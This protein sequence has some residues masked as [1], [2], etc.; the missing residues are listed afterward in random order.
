MSDFNE[1]LGNL[2]LSPIGEAR[3]TPGAIRPPDEEPAPSPVRAAARSALQ[4]FL[5]DRRRVRAVRAG[6][7]VVVI[8][9]TSRPLVGGAACR[10]H[11]G[12]EPHRLV[13]EA[14]IAFDDL[15][16]VVERI[17]DPSEGQVHRAWAV[18]LKNGKGRLVRIWTFGAACNEDEHFYWVRSD[19]RYSE[20]P[21]GRY[22]ELEQS[23]R[24]RLAREMIS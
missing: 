5:G 4:R 17:E 16:S 1:I 20:V 12:V 18:P 10:V 13:E 23:L 9:V 7:R 22:R 14:D 24:A 15:G 6:D 8:V 21:R 3:E 19:G 11:A 2:E